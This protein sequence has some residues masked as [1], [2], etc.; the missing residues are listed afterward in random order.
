MNFQKSR[1]RS[2]V[3]SALVAALM[4]A[5]M[6]VPTFAA[7]T[8]IEFSYV[9][10]VPAIDVAVALGKCAGC[11]EVLPAS[12]FSMVVVDK[13]GA[14]VDGYLSA[15][16]KTLVISW[17]YLESFLLAHEE[18][19][20]GLSILGWTPADYYGDQEYL[21][22]PIDTSALT[23]DPENTITLAYHPAETPPETTPA[24]EPS[25]TTPVHSSTDLAEIVSS[26]NLSSVFDEVK[27]LLP[28]VCVVIVGYIGL[29]KGVS[30]LQNILHSA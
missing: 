12:S 27:A 15:D 11:N 16:G 22:V 7:E 1:L 9:E 6:I 5:F 13:I 8:E 3:C 19:C 21:A 20:S 23:A 24:V 2:I 26:E 10:R 18:V 17:D 4:A 25:E 29:R 28:V 30:F 14:A